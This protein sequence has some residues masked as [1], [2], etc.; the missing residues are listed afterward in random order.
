MKV[1]ALGVSFPTHVHTPRLELWIKCYGRFPELSP[2][3]ESIEVASRGSDMGVS[4]LAAGRARDK[5]PDSTWAPTWLPW[6]PM[7]FAWEPRWAVSRLQLGAHMVCLKT[8]VFRLITQ[9]GCVLAHYLDMS[10]CLELVFAP[11][12]WKHQ[13]IN[14]MTSISIKLTLQALQS[15]T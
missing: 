13:V 14:F 12:P 2:N 15:R 8:H 1:L 9:M 3:L 4:T 6:A 5:D 10:S 7:W 11:L